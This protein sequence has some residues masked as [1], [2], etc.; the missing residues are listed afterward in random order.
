MSFSSPYFTLP[1]FTYFRPKSV[2]E[3]VNLLQ[4]YG[5]DA[6]LMAGG[7]GLINMLKER[8]MDPKALIDLK[9]IP[10]LHKIEYSESKGLLVGATVTL[11][12][13]LANRQLKKI[14]PALWESISVLSDNNLR[15]R[16]TLVGDL[17]EATPWVDSP[18]SLIAYQSSVIIT[19]PSGT[20]TLPVE[21]FVRGMAQLD[22]KNDEL[23]TAVSIPKPGKDSRGRYYKFAK[24]T[25][26]GLVNLAVV[27]SGYEHG[28]P[29]NTRFVYGG[30]ADTPVVATGITEAFR[31]GVT[32]DSV[33]HASEIIKESLLW[34]R[35]SAQPLEDNLA[36][37]EYRKH[38]ME[39]VTLQALREVLG[40]R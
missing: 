22:L 24:G 20:R 26:F 30:I 29:R 19:G 27:A 4:K 32:G 35:N 1:K 34:V 16:S 31:R 17:C 18:P 33:A 39:V 12:E 13:I 38:L 40:V 10:E 37:A 6:R 7:V 28:I 9:G 8:L 15:N 21:S 2:G 14:Y 36:S 25:E 11:N 3:A 23:V 5:D